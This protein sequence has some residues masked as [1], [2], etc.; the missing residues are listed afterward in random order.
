MLCGTII[1]AL[2]LFLITS[3]FLG[4]T[5]ASASLIL[6][7]L[8]ILVYLGA[9]LVLFAYIW[10]YVPLASE[11]P[12]FYS[13][14]PLPFF[15]LF[16][17]DTLVPSSLSAYLYATALVLYLVGL[18]FWAMVVVVNLLDLSLGGFRS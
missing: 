9:L 14:V 12:P 7:L 18:L 17:F 13:F 15:F 16:I 11:Q 10:M 2:S 3:L 6:S 1:R 5:L 4:S 8:T